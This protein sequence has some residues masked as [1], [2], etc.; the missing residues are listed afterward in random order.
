MLSNQKG[1]ALTLAMGA[2]VFVGVSV[3]VVIAILG[4]MDAQVK[5]TR[6]VNDVESLVLY[7]N[8]VLNNRD[9]C[10]YAMR[11]HNGQ[12]V[13]IRDP[14]N[15]GVVI[16]AAAPPMVPK[17]R[18][19]IPRLYL[20]DGD[21]AAPPYNVAPAGNPVLCSSTANGPNGVALPN[22]DPNCPRFPNVILRNMQF[23]FHNDTNNHRP[24]QYRNQN[25][26][27]YL[28]SGDFE[29]E[30]DFPQQAV[31]GGDFKTRKFPLTILYDRLGDGV[32]P[33]GLIEMC[34]TRESPVL[35]C[36]QLGG[37]LDP[38]TGTC[39]QMFGHCEQGANRPTVC[40]G[41]PN[42]MCN[43]AFGLGW[44]TVYY[45]ATVLPQMQ[46]SCQCMNVCTYVG[47]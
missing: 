36:T 3:M 43:A 24:F 21:P 16:P 22:A 18:I 19:Q 1:D 32:N 34:Y 20:V 42:N 7:A 44:T 11:Q 8:Q 29:M 47:P 37:S 15:P 46:V 13:L 45:M 41:F 25:N 28:L 35:L 10:T 23:E 4:N 30:F 38:L 39:R 40:S 27:Y 17:T 12:A 6:M 26:R 33:P 14:G 9:L 2:A 31:L 5:R